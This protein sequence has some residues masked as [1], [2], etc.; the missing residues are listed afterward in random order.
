MISFT[1]NII[2]LLF[3]LFL[4]AVAAPVSSSFAAQVSQAQMEQF[5]K[6]PPSQ[7]QALAKSMG[8]DINALKGKLSGNNDSDNTTAN[9]ANYP[10]GTQFDSQGNPIQENYQKEEKDDFEEV[11]ELEPFGYDVFANAPQTF[12]PT[13]DIAIPSDYMV[14]PGDRISIQVFGKEV[15]ELELEVNI[16]GAQIKKIK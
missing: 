11:K 4:A 13:M 16:Y 8:I 6:L 15:N 3:I 12:A 9:T 5:K 1:K 2:A 10:R 14:A 7:Q